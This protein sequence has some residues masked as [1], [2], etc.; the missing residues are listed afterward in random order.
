MA[1]IS[2]YRIKWQSGRDAGFILISHPPPAFPLTHQK[3]SENLLPSPPDSYHSASVTEHPSF[4]IPLPESC[5]PTTNPLFRRP[6]FGGGGAPHPERGRTRRISP[7]GTGKW[8][9]SDTD[10]PASHRERRRDSALGRGASR[11]PRPGLPRRG[12]EFYPR[13]RPPTP[14]PRPSGPSS[15]PQ[16]TRRSRRGL[17]SRAHLLD[18]VEAGKHTDAAVV[19][20]GELLRQLLLTGLQHGARHGGSDSGGGGGSVVA[21]AAGCLSPSHRPAASAATSVGPSPLPPATSASGERAHS[22]RAPIPRR[23]QS[24]P[25]RTPRGPFPRSSPRPGSLLPSACRPSVPTPR[26]PRPQPPPSRLPGLLH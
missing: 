15:P 12:R 23:W 17:A 25:R 2:Q 19:E 14:P 9:L 16:P 8:L 21:A 11:R 1:F 6:R 10:R 7:L 5:P 13:R 20:D 26:C 4:P 3:L 24:E 22:P 18:V